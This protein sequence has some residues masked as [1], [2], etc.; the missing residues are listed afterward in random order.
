MTSENSDPVHSVHGNITSD[1]TNTGAAMF[2]RHHPTGAHPAGGALANECCC[3][4]I[5]VNNN[6]QGVTNSTLFGS[7]VVMRDPGV[8]LVFRQGSRMK[9]ERS[10]VQIKTD[11]KISSSVRFELWIMLALLFVFILSIVCNLTL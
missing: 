3:V 7:K 11:A 9:H 1:G 8:T 5:Y 4:N 6:I 10:S 2:I